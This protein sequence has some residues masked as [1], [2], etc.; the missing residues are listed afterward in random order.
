MVKVRHRVRA[1]AT[2]RFLS[3]VARHSDAWKG[4]RTR[5]ERQPSMKT[6]MT[7]STQDMLLAWDSPPGTGSM[8][9]SCDSLSH[10]FLEALTAL[11]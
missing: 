3:A 2:A 1:C 5:L 7:T 4:A 9:R 11:P 6:A 8:S 10:G